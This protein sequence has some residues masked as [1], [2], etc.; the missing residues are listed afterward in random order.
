MEGFYKK[1]CDI[2]GEP[3]Y[4]GDWVLQKANEGRCMCETCYKG[5]EHDDIVEWFDGYWS[6]L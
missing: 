2:C 6:A 5:L 1:R 3:L 4:N